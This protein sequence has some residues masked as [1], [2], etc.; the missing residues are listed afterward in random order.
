[1]IDLE[2][3]CRIAIQGY[4]GDCTYSSAFNGRGQRGKRHGRT[5]LDN[6]CCIMH[7]LRRYAEGLS[8]PRVLPIL[9]PG[10]NATVSAPTY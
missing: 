7:E 9:E 5:L 4:F 10:E 8:I 1:M 3:I 2:T 6:C